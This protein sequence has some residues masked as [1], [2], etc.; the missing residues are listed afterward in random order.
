MYCSAGM[1]E[2]VRQPLP[3]PGFSIV[4][5]MDWQILQSKG[6]LEKAQYTGHTRPRPVGRGPRRGRRGI[7]AVEPMGA[8]TSKAE[9][10][11]SPHT[12]GRHRAFRIHR[13]RAPNTNGVAAL[14]QKAIFE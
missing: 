13:F 10:H 7:P 9:L 14:A 8:W 3:V 4:A 6:L 12:A 5:L 11:W 2:R 1:R